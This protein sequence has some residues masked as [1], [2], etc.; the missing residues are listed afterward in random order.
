MFVIC[1]VCGHSSLPND[2]VPQVIR[3]AMQHG[4]SFFS[5][6][7]LRQLINKI[8]CFWKYFIKHFFIVRYKVVVIPR[9][10]IIKQLVV[11]AAKIR[12]KSAGNYKMKTKHLFHSGMSLCRDT[13]FY[14]QSAF[15]IVTSIIQPVYSGV[16]KA[17]LNKSFCFT[18]SLF[19]PQNAVM[20]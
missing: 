1:C 3:S 20:R 11:K 4:R 15:R 14:K 2:L 7:K 17:V 6:Y 18:Y 12:G 19:C 5:I 9:N 10:P 8:F 13:L 16:K